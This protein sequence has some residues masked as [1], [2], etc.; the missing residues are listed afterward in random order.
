MAGCPLGGSLFPD[1]PAGCCA[2]NLTLIRPTDRRRAVLIDVGDV[3]R[4][5]AP[6]SDDGAVVWPPVLT[7]RGLGM[8]PGPQLGRQGV[9]VVSV[10][11]SPG[12]SG[13]VDEG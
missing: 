3:E 2:V 1:I 7:G 13:G 4:I 9:G 11:G 6:A 10:T 8:G 5:P 12:H